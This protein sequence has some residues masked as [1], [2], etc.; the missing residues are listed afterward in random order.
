MAAIL[1]RPKCGEASTGFEHGRLK[2]PL[3]GRR[4][5]GAPVGR[6]PNAQ[7]DAFEYFSL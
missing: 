4:F 5:T 1:S 6:R 7:K 2:N 3:S